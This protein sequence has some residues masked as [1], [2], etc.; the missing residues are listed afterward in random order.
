VDPRL[1]V[2]A[3]V[4]GVEAPDGTAIAFPAAAARA[5]LESGDRIAVQGVELTLDGGGIRAFA[6]GGELA[7]HQ[8]F[9]FAWSQFR[10]DTLL[11]EN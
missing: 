8:A 7:A 2:Q 10:P 4:I 5:V 6:D 3:A 9:W 11:W 1:G